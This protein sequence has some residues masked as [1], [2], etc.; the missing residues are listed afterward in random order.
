MDK[1]NIFDITG[2]EPINVIFTPLMFLLPL[3]FFL[4]FKFQI[5]TLHQRCWLLF[6]I[7]AYGVH[8]AAVLAFNSKLNFFHYSFFF[9]FNLSIQRLQ[10]SIPVCFSYICCSVGVGFVSCQYFPLFSPNIWIGR[11]INGS[12]IVYES[13]LWWT[14]VKLGDMLSTGTGRF[15]KSCRGKLRRDSRSHTVEPLTA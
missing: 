14:G 10:K 6:N 11:F 9:F 8:L 1:K 2:S 5:T 7:I 12:L 13:C 4:T 3:F 15:F